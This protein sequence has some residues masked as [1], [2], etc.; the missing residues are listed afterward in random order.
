MRALSQLLYFL[1]SIPGLSFLT[2]M[3]SNLSRAS[4]FTSR[5]ASA[6]RSMTASRKNKTEESE[7]N[8]Q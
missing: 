8:S 4:S 7:E 3:A 1:G 5:G 2:R 6:A